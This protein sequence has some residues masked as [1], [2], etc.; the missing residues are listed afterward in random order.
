LSGLMST[1]GLSQ[2]DAATIEQEVMGDTKEAIWYRKE[3]EKAWA[4]K[5]LNRES[6]AYLTRLVGNLDLDRDDAAAIER[7][8]MGCTKEAALNTYLLGI[9]VKRLKGLS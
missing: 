3:V 5:Q 8:V 2:E 4:N 7:E 6:A 9:F 1:L